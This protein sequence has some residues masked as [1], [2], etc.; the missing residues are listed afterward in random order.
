[1][2]HQWQTFS[3][4]VEQVSSLF[5]LLDLLPYGRQEQWQDVPDGWPQ[6]PTFTRW[7]SAEDVAD[8]YGAA[9]RDSD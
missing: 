2:F 3:R 6:S 4:G 9:A 5:G 8:W 7:A 1:V